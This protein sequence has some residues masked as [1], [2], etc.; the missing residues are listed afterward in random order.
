MFQASLV[1]QIIHAAIA[2]SF[3]VF[4]L[5]PISPVMGDFSEIALKYPNDITTDRAGG[6]AQMAR[7]I[8]PCPSPY[9]IVKREHTVDWG[10]GFYNG[11]LSRPLRLLLPSR[12]EQDN[13]YVHSG[14]GV[15]FFPRLRRLRPTPRPVRPPRVLRCPVARWIRRNL[16]VVRFPRLQRWNV[17]L[18]CGFT[19]S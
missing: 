13:N 9:A 3:L 18:E 6:V 15:V 1:N 10:M 12:K 5:L 14:I 2:D 19:W 16:S 11:W 7:D 8:L 4:L 17:C